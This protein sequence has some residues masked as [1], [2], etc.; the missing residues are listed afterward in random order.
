MPAWMNRT[1]TL[2]STPRVVEALTPR[3]TED[4]TCAHLTTQVSPTDKCGGLFV[5]CV[6]C[7]TIIR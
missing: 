4:D 6:D 2:T 7:R 3:P 1:S 5:I